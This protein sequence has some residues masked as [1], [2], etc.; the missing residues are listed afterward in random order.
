MENEHAPTPHTRT[1]LRQVIL[2]GFGAVFLLVAASAVV[3]L[4]QVAEF[5]RLIDSGRVATEK[6][7]LI[8]ALIE[9]ARSRTRMTG[10]MI[11]TA[12]PFAKDELRMRLD[13][14]AGRFAQLREEFVAMGL[15]PEEEALLAQNGTF[16]GPTLEAQRRAT[17]LAMSE[18]PQVLAEAQH[19]LMF[20]VFP[21]QGR[22]IDNF[23]TM[24]QVQRETVH[25]A[26]L[27]AQGRYRQMLVLMATLSGGSLVM[28]VLVTLFV[29]RK[30][31]HIEAALHREKERAQV[32]LRSIGDG[33]IATDAAGR[34]QYMN[35][36]A[37][38]L[39][40]RRLEEVAQSPV[41]QVLNAHDEGLDRHVAH[42]V[43][44]LVQHG[45][46][47]DP[48]DDVVLENARGE[49][50]HIA[51]TLSR[52]REVDGHIGGV[53]LSFQDVTESR[54]L[55]KRIEFHA[56]HDALTGLL[57][58][59][60]FEERVSR[61]LGIYDEGVHVLC[62]MDLD[63]FKQVNDNCG[64][65]AGDELLRQLSGRLRAEVRQ[66]DLVAR[67]GGDEFA[68]FL[69]NTSLPRALE[70]A[71][72]LVESVRG[73]RFLWEGK[74]FRVGAS[75]GLVQAP[76]E[77]DAS[78]QE[79]L[80]AAD[81][82]CYQAKAAG[83]GRVVVAPSAGGRDGPC[84]EEP[85]REGEWLARVQAA[86]VG[87]GFVLYGQPIAQ[88]SERAVGNACVEVLLRLADE[89]GEPAVPAA[90]LSTAERHGLMPRVDEWV[91][92]RVL[93]RVRREDGAGPVYTVNLSGQSVA[94]AEFV[95][96]LAVLLAGP[97]LDCSRVCFELGETTALA[98]LEAARAFMQ[99]VRGLGC[100]VGLDNFG[101]GLSSFAYLKG[102]PL[103]LI[104]IDGEFVQHVATDRAARAMV[105][106]IHGVA[107][108]LD[109][110]T[111]AMSVADGET[112]AELRR[113]GVDMAQGFHLGAPVPLEAD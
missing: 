22:I 107:S 44:R 64:H 106:A 30:T 48:S 111:V 46:P 104:K 77:G 21:R 110:R 75:V 82:A 29:V 86:I 113:I 69:L 37:E 62:A 38:A 18:D 24:A 83:R 8:T 76:E 56:H 63:R 42:L 70:L 74:A 9:V 41:R 67:M 3:Q 55:A 53:I 108:A 14:E 32:T 45:T 43:H 91:V 47:V 59:R 103:D 89:A 101:S 17:E 50:L 80:R 65:A 58:R 94:D 33:V 84:P 25:A 102:L 10:E 40:G 109:L 57:N 66:G 26:T 78:F 96:R 112:E 28:A 49:R 20:E 79:L 11:L 19:L 2:A 98:D 15:T 31:G 35:P 23:M 13:A 34:V 12:D 93:E 27:Q 52:I 105:E 88:F 51:L 100:R 6:M 61:A 99:R 92:R 7:G 81:Q 85:C 1:R 68:F 36:I 5:A 16:V 97:G 73:F 90:F 72:N 4:R 95:E 39:T 60:A 54:R 87:D 71:D